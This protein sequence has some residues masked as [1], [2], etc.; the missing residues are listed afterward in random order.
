MVILW[1]IDGVLIQ[2][3]RYFLQQIEGEYEGAI[4]ILTEYY[5]SGVNRDCDRGVRDPCVEIRPYIERL[6]WKGDARSYLLAQYGFEAQLVDRELLAEIEASRGRAK[7]YLATN[8]N[9]LRKA[10]LARELRIDSVFDGA[11]FSCDF[12]RIKPELGYFEHVLS[13]LRAAGDLGQRE[14]VVFFDDLAEN[15][16]GARQAGIESYRVGSRE[17]ARALFAEVLG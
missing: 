2:H 3:E 14:R 13:R 16:E 5:S 12:G 1:D 15:V 9:P 6:G 4:A 10:V 7:H 8:Q 11:F 17:E